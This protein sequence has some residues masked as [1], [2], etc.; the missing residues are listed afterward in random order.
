MEVF[1][2]DV[3][4][5]SGLSE[6]KVR[7]SQLNGE[8]LVYNFDEVDR[9]EAYLSQGMENAKSEEEARAIAHKRLWEEIGE[10]KLTQMAAQAYKAKL[11][12]MKYQIE[13]F[14]AILINEEALIYGVTDL[15]K[16]LQRYLQWKSKN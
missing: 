10:E 16:A 15:N 5:F 1:T 3:I 8:I 4:N 7:L 11:L 14:P 6:V 12:A 13:K 9:L 2:S